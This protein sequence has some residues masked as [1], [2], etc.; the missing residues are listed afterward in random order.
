MVQF[1]KD[2]NFNDDDKIDYVAVLIDLFK[3]P[4]IL[5]AEID[6]V[7]ANSAADIE[8]TVN[9]ACIYNEQGYKEITGDKANKTGDI[10]GNYPETTDQSNHKKKHYTTP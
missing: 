8:A 5:A 9:T 1:W 2:G 7:V 10:L 3:Q 6:R 4:N